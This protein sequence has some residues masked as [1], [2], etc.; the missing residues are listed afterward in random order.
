MGAQA[1]HP[2][3]GLDFFPRKERLLYIQSWSPEERSRARRV[4]KS[5]A[6][7]DFI[8]NFVRDLTQGTIELSSEMYNI[9]C[10]WTRFRRFELFV[11]RYINVDDATSLDIQPV[12]PLQ[13]EHSIVPVF[14]QWNNGQSHM[15]WMLRRSGP[16]GIRI[17]PH[18]CR[19][20]LNTPNILKA[21]AFSPLAFQNDVQLLG[22]SICR[23]ASLYSLIVSV[24]EILRVENDRV[25]PM[26]EQDCV[27]FNSLA[28]GYSS[29]LSVAPRRTS[30][31]KIER[32]RSSG[33]GE[34]SN[35]M[36][37]A[38]NIWI[39]SVSISESRY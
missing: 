9:G 6:P 7:A 37:S 17:E 2:E 1:S 19:P 18:G 30:S 13:P 14:L 3:L 12:L 16:V 38:S 4:R 8:C 31:R 10:D 22:L 33:A 5:I 25:K 28:I 32:T 15:I 11:A 34:S 20:D 29:T 21:T 26:N 24:C 36:P 27:A 35:P 39:S 23:V